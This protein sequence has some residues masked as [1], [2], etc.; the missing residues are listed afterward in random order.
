MSSPSSSN[1]H[2]HSN[3]LILSSPSS[4]AAM[5]Q[6]NAAPKQ[7]I[8]GP[9]DM[10]DDWPDVLPRHPS[11]NSSSSIGIHYSKP[12]AKSSSSNHNTGSAGNGNA[13]AAHMPTPERIHTPPLGS[14][15]APSDHDSA[16]ASSMDEMKIRG[17]GQPKIETEVQSALK[18][19]PTSAATLAAAK[20]DI[21]PMNDS[22]LDPKRAK[23]W[24]C[25]C[26]LHS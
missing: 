6:Q 21:N 20:G 8:N 2:N 13:A 22:V 25:L 18:A 9:R 15:S 23:R 1:N 5:P 12:F 4:S 19:E 3:S 16:N 7:F 17:P 10:V 11:C 24:G 26:F 14:S